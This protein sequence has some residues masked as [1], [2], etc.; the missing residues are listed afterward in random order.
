MAC[1]D[2]QKVLASGDRVAVQ[3]DGTAITSNTA[4]TPEKFNTRSAGVGGTCGK[5]GTQSLS[6]N[7]ALSLAFNAFGGVR[8]LGRA[9]GV[10]DVLRELRGHLH[11]VAVGHVHRVRHRRVRGAVEEDT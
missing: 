10:G 11:A 7:P 1:T 5:A 6:G 8:Q 9:A 3:R 2:V 4:I